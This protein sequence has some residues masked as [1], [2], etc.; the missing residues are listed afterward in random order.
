MLKFQI[1]KINKFRI[2]N[3][4][5]KIHNGGKNVNLSDRNIG[6]TGHGDFSARPIFRSYGLKGLKVIQAFALKCWIDRIASIMRSIAI[7]LLL[8]VQYYQSEERLPCE[9][10]IL[11]P[12]SKG[13]NYYL[14]K[15][16]ICDFIYLFLCGV[17]VGVI[18]FLL[19]FGGPWIFFERGGGAMN[20]FAARRG[21]HEFF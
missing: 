9:C 17:G 1:S 12:D 3:G 6:L 21:G 19:Q 11:H 8:S 15:N 10:S 13:D 16:G 20:F 18:N 7:Y 14:P 5:I 2:H 4:G